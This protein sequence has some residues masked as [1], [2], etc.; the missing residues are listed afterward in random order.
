LS[1][2]L[3]IFGFGEAADLDAAGF[4]AGALDAPDFDAAMSVILK[5]NESDT[6]IYTIFRAF[7]IG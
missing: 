7:R 2:T 5:K 3:S 4:D 1:V 6:R